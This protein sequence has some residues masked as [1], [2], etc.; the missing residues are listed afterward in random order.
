MFIF[1][2]ALFMYQQDSIGKFMEIPFYQHKETNSAK[3]DKNRLRQCFN[4]FWRVFGKN[5]ENI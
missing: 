3:L 4:W 5:M 1:G 2:I